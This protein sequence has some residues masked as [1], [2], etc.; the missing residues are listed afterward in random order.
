M[1]SRTAYGVS[2]AFPTLATIQRLFPQAGGKEAYQDRQGSSIASFVGLPYRKVSQGE[3]FNE[4]LRRQFEI[5]RYLSGLTRT[6]QL[7]PKE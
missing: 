7:K 1:S 4:M 6:G 5:K 3:Q 2:N